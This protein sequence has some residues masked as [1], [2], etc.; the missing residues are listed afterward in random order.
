MCWPHDLQHSTQTQAFGL[1]EARNPPPDHSPMQP[2]SNPALGSSC[3]QPPNRSNPP[4]GSN[5]HSER[6]KVENV[7]WSQL[8]NTLRTLET[9]VELFPPL[10]SAI[11]ALNECLHIV[12]KAAQNRAEYE[13]LADEFQSMVDAIKQYAGE[14]ELEPSNG[15]IANIAQC[16]QRQVADI[17]QKQDH[18]DG[19]R[20]L[21]ATC[22]QEGV[23][24]SYRQVER[25]FRQLQTDL[26]MRTKQE[27]RK[28]HE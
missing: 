13:K 26:S 1:E 16:I 22:D 12:Q 21:N 6:N 2:F 18:G 27:V 17:K 5:G 28:I 23:L 9:S 8:R 14:L 11:G 20:V 25:L 19:R 10:K 3:L 4:T 7:A 24:E 15:S